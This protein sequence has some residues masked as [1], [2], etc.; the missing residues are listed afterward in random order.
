MSVYLSQ[1]QTA[2]NKITKPNINLKPGRANHFVLGYDLMLTS[3]LHLKVEAYYQDLYNIPVMQNSYYSMLNNPGGYFN[4]SLINTGTGKNIGV[5]VTF[6]KFL[7]NNFYYLFTASV[8][9]SKY[10]GGDGIERNGR[11]N[12]NFAFNLL[13]GKEFYT[14]SQNVWGVNLKASYNG[15]EYYI[16]VDLQQSISEN[17]EVLCSGQVY[18]QNL[19][20]FLY[21]DFTVNYRIN[22]TKTSMVF[23]AQA[24]NILNNKTV[25]GYSYNNY[26]KKVDEQSES[27]IIPMLSVKYEF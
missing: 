5:D 8:F 3:D 22:Y 23:T 27:G 16:P 26:S 25:I 7:S 10:K 21:L 6:E 15:G 13:A 19:K 12:S 18:T 11:Y 1:N 14:K 17:R 9:N 20:P 24:K 4:D 2:D